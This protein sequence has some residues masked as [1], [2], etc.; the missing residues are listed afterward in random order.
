LFDNGT[1]VQLKARFEGQ[2]SAQSIQEAL[3]S[4]GQ[5]QLTRAQLENI[6]GGLLS[7]SQ[8]TLN[9]EAVDAAGNASSVDI[10]FT[11]DTTAPAVVGFMLTPGS[12]TATPGD[13]RTSKDKVTIE[14]QA[15]PN[16]QLLLVNT[17]AVITA[18]ATG[19]FQFADVPLAIGQN[20]LT[21]EAFDS[22]GNRQSF[23]QT[24]TRDDLRDGDV[25]VDWNRVTLEAIR[26]DR[27][28]PPKAAYIMALVHAAVFDAVNAVA[29]QYQVYQIDAQAGDGTSMEA[30]AAAAA[31]QILMDYFPFQQAMLERELAESLAEVPDGLSEDLGM[32]LGTSVADQFLIQ[33]QDDGSEAIVAHEP[34]TTPGTWRPTP[35]SY[36]GAA[37]PQWPAVVPFALIDG[38][39][40]R[41]EGPPELDSAQYA[42]EYNQVKDLGSKTSTTRTADQT[43]IAF[44]WAD[45][46]GTY[47]P[48]G[49]WNQIAGEA[50][51]QSNHSLIENAR[52]FALLNLSLADSGIAAWDAKYTYNS[53]RPIT[54]IQQG[55]FDGNSATTGNPNWKPLIATP[56]FPAYVSGHSTFSA[57]AATV[58]AQSFG[59]QFNFATS[60]FGL[61]G[62][63]R[64]YTSFWQAA[65]EAGMS[66]IYGGIHFMAD[67]VDGTILGRDVAG[68]VLDNFLKPVNASSQLQAGL[69][70]DTAPAG[71]ENR[72]KITADPTIAG[73]V[74]TQT[75]VLKA[76]VNGAA[77]YQ[78]VSATIGANGQFLLDEATIAQLNGGSLSDGFQTVSLQA[79]DVQGNL[80]ES[81]E[82][83]FVLDRTKPTATF[84]APL[85]NA[86]QSPTAHLKGVIEDAFSRGGAVR[87][88]LDGQAFTQI[89]A[90]GIG[91]F[92]QIIDG[93]GLGV[94][95]HQ[96]T[97]EVYDAAG[98]AIQK[99]VSFFVSDQFSVKGQG[100]T[101]WGVQTQEALTLV[102]GN[103]LVVQKTTP[104]ELGITEG[105]R[106]IAFEV[107]ALWDKDDINAIAEDRL[108][109]YL[110]DA[111]NPNQTLLDGGEPGTAL[112]SL[113]GTQAE[114]RSGLVRFD[115]QRVIIDV[116]SLPE[117]TTGNLIFQLI[118]LDGDTDSSV[119]ISNLTNT[120]DLLGTA[121]EVFPVMINRAIAGNTLSIDSFLSTT[122]V[123]TLLSNVRVDEATG[124][125]IADLRVQN[126]GDVPVSR[127]MAIVFPNLPEGVTIV[128]ASGI[129]AN[130]SPYLNITPAM[131]D[132]DLAAGALSEMV[133]VVF[134]NADFAQFDLQTFVL[135]GQMDQAP[136]WEDLGSLSV[137]AGGRLEIPLTA[138]DPD[139]DRVTL[140]IRNAENLPTGRLEN[141]Q[142]VFLP[143]PEDIG[144]YSFT[145]VATSNGLETTQDVTLT[146][147][148]DPVT[149]TRISGV[150]QDT[151]QMPLAGV[152]IDVD[153]WQTVTDAEGR[154]TVEMPGLPPSN[155]LRVHGQLL[156]LSEEY[157][158]IAEK[159]PLMLEH[160]VYAGVNN[161]IARPIYLPALDIASG[162][163]IDPAQDMVITSNRLLGASV[164]VVAG[165]LRDQ[166]GLLF[167]DILSITE[168]PVN[169]TPA[170]LPPNLYP[171]LVVT[172]QPGDM[173]F[174]TPAPLTLPNRSGYAPGLEM[175]LWS[176]NPTTG[177]FDN[178][179]KG[180]V[181]DDGSVIETIEGGVR[182]SSWHFWGFPP[183]GQDP[184]KNPRN[185]D[186]GCNECE[187]G[188]SFTSE[189]LLHSG[190]VVET[191]NL[192]SYESLGQYTGINTDL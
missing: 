137:M 109:V 19:C 77:T 187:A 79:Y 158:F 52:L 76:S 168:V 20:R 102:E 92:D 106:T 62:V 107:E 152:L 98:N 140:S 119:R 146:V 133:Q 10:R 122:Q 115:G 180:R 45:G 18:D 142:M 171:D 110:V 75:I 82:V 156:E 88:S 143:S 3:G 14:G 30:A 175:D 71:S 60:T 49:H 182:N 97:V 21:I 15:D 64:N 72:D 176:I 117:G 155:T 104:I 191:H 7:D 67:N 172:I 91:Q 26:V 29:Q 68:Y 129:H 8:Y 157:P 43:E 87:Y 108:V 28:A 153:G 74:S 73:Q 112:F 36:Y 27:T 84:D 178:V 132:G 85:E 121:G 83:T 4:N 124:Q 70:H 125:V 177:A 99:S 39:Q 95:E 42:A 150:I 141:G 103:S 54:A 31:F 51:I 57:A 162:Q 174:T 186:P 170:A 9:I 66:R 12:D 63:E 90:D 53:W 32:A 44:F 17:G 111:N 126:I 188:E 128:G 184:S 34:D 80:L 40:F 11:L 161:V 114:Y 134:S 23:D 165:S 136:W 147:G 169:L 159:L 48:P 160:E 1:I 22:A 100:T 144:T 127:Q 69:A 56:L 163:V 105:T 167:R 179:G 166:S 148:A 2:S 149:T 65:D 6:Y 5:F 131:L 13:S 120:V 33:Q 173:V 16:A 41:P 81:L 93:A 135:T 192:I 139:G 89:K 190:A 116:S 58:L 123:K 47:T 164:T 55:E 94:G 61:P 189:V 25:V 145:L 101:G 46:P 118:N 24:I 183:I 78:D 50:A 154:F 96:L 185:Q 35:G 130:G 38:T 59:D 113:N 151:N 138:I 86:I 181:S 37:L